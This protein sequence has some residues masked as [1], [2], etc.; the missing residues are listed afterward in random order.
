MAVTVF[1][2]PWFNEYCDLN[3][4]PNNGGSVTIY[5][6]GTT[7]P[8]AVYTDSAGTIANTNPVVFNS[9]G[10]PVA[11]IWLPVVDSYDC[12]VK[13][14]LG[15]VVYELDHIGLPPLVPSTTVQ[16]LNVW[17]DPLAV[18]ASTGST[19]FY[20][21]G[22]WDT[23][24][25][26][27]RRVKVTMTGGSQSLAYATV[28][29]AAYDSGT[30]RT[31]VNVVVDGTGNI[32]T[33]GGTFHVYYSVL[34]SVGVATENIIYA[35]DNVG[36]SDAL[37][38]NLNPAIYALIDKS[39]F[40]I[41]VPTTNT[42]T[43]PSLVINGLTAKTIVKDGGAALVAGDLPLF[44]QLVYDTVLD[45]YVLMNP[46]LIGIALK[47]VSLQ[48]QIDSAV[49]VN[50]TQNTTLSS[51]QTQ[52]D[53]ITTK[54]LTYRI[55]KSGTSTVSAGSSLVV[56][57]PTPFPTT[58]ESPVCSA[59]GSGSAVGFGANATLTTITLFNPYTASQN[60]NWVVTGT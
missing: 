7:T 32:S 46:S 10:Y 38:A 36:T 13:D 45:K 15:N 58:V 12:I 16:D 29:S 35:A 40:I 1:L 30:N 20:I 41:R 18:S 5:L 37:I 33:D 11:P 50:G 42:L 34:D 60:I 31:T 59:S 43:A 52:I 24:F 54:L 47:D 27:G 55:V 49:S 25:N 57:F 39:T 9:Q 22:V 21:E 26:A 4:L 19:S 23:I 51:L 17:I 8:A 56:T 6:T 3:D 53:A 28:K 44:S 2:S 14:A 48:S